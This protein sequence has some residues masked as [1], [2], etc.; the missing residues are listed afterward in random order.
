MR[1]SSRLLI[2][3]V[4]LASRGVYI[5]AYGTTKFRQA[6]CSCHENRTMASCGAV[7]LALVLFGSAC[8]AVGARP[9][10]FVVFLADE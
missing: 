6:T 3:T 2:N 7:L 5:D 8:L 9:P 10:N 1:G 4:D